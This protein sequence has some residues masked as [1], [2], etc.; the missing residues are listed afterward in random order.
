[1]AQMLG[2]FSDPKDAT[3][4]IQRI[5]DQV[6]PLVQAKTDKIYEEFRAIQ[7]REQVVAGVIYLIK[8]DVGGRKFIHLK[9][10]QVL[11]CNGGGLELLG[12]QQDKTKEEPLVPF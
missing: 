9:V 12:L 3:E 1:M 6:K 2:G 11:P 5:C 7:Y 8:V 10:L 4:D